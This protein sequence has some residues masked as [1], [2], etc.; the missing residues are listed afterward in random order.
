M[1]GTFP[2]ALLALSLTT[3]ASAQRQCG[4]TSLDRPARRPE[5]LV[6]TAWLADHLGDPD[7]VIVHADLGEAGYRAGHLP[8]ARYADVMAFT[9]GDHD[10]QAPEASRRL[11]EELGI[12]NDTRV[13]LYGET[14]HMGWLYVVL[15][16]LGHGDRTALLDG[17]LPQWRAEGRPVETGAPAAA[18]PGRFRVEVRD[19]AIVTTEWLRARLG[20]R[21]VALI[22]VRSAEEY[23]AGHI[24]TARH[25]DWSG[26]FT[27]PADAL[28]GNASPFVSA[29]RLDEVF[30]AAGAAPGRD[31]V[32]YCAVGVR[33]SLMYL[34]AKS[35]GYTPR[36]YDGSWAAWSAAG[37]PVATGTQPGSVR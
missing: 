1:K 6:S 17:G 5:L 22:D 3:P 35:L 37:L 26:T 9:A 29:D 31:V 13:V 36:L 10:L 32:L 23:A 18:A 15:D 4:P 19:D 14:W 11:L 24:P 7:V 30:R 27:R 16:R 33:A 12:T 25:L 21:R 2:L 8:G 34:L 20:S 28:E